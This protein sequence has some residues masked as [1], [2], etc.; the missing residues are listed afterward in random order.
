VSHFPENNDHRTEYVE[1]GERKT[2]F[3][4][5]LFKGYKFG[6]STYEKVAVSE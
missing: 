6:V 2:M 5:W 1:E 3:G 4:A